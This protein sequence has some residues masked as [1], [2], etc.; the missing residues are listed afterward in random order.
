LEISEAEMGKRG[1]EEVPDGKRR[2]KVRMLLE[3]L[4]DQ[5]QRFAARCEELVSFFILRETR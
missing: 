2:K 1:K 5:A 4:N 3:L